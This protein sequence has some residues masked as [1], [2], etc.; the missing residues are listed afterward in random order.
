MKFKVGQKVSFLN[1]ARNGIIKKIINDKMVSVEIEDGFDVPVM[2]HELVS[3]EAYLS[4]GPTTS[5]HTTNQVTKA[6]VEDDD[7][8]FPDRAV[9]N[10]SAKTLL[11]KGLYLA[12]VPVNSGKPL[13]DGVYVTLINYTPYDVIFTYATKKEQKFVHYAYERATSNSRVVLEFIDAS[14]IQEWSS[15]KFQIL[16]YKEESADAIDP[17][18]SI[19]NINPIKF[20]RDETYKEEELIGETAILLPLSD[21]K[22][23]VID[24][25]MLIGKPKG[26]KVVGHINDIINKDAFPEKHIVSKGIAEVDLHIDELLDSIEGISNIQ[27]L[28]TQV[29]YFRKMLESAIINHLQRIIFI[30]GVGNGKLKAEIRKILAEDYP[31]LEI[32]DASMAKYG[33]GATEIKIP[34]NN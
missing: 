8:S 25:P 31:K 10:L 15:I 13:Q 12:Y 4:E 1:E 20:Y 30:H 27:M 16:Y 11:K 22:E 3:A 17:Q 33:M 6:P 2:E 9:L 19:A 7:N 24:E 28:G 26:I 18:I 23:E 14:E 34:V 32:Y 21:N 5:N 29:D